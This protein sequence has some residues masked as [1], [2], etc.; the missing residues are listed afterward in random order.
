MA[1]T[2]IMVNKLPLGDGPSAFG[3]WRI[4]G[5][6][7]IMESLC[8]VSFGM[9]DGFHFSMLVRDLDDSEIVGCVVY[10]ALLGSNES[11]R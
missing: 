6:N 4:F 2:M 10:L 1:R 3:V 8:R 9:R 5:Y 7:Q 11:Y